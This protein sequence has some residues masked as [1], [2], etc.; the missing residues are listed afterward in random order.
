VDVVQSRSGKSF[1]AVGLAM[2][3]FL[4]GVLSFFFVGGGHAASAS[5]GVIFSTKGCAAT[6]EIGASTATAKLSG[7]CPGSY[8]IVSNKIPRN[9]VGIE[10]PSGQVRIGVA[11][12][13]GGVV[14]LPSCGAFQ[15]D[16]SK[17]NTPPDTPAHPYAHVISA[18][19]ALLAPCGPSTGEIAAEIFR[20]VN[21]T[22][23]TTPAPNAGASLSVPDPLMKSGTAF[24]LGAVLQ[25][26][27]EALGTWTMSAVAPT[28]WVFS[29]CG[30]SGSTVQSL[31]DQSLVAPASVSSQP[32]PTAA[33]ETQTNAGG[34]NH[35]T[36]QVTVTATGHSLVAFYANALATAPTTTTSTSTTSTSTTS[37]TVP[38]KSGSS[39]T[40]GTE[41]V[42]CASLATAT[43]S[44]TDKPSTVPAFT[45]NP[46]LPTTGVPLFPELAMAGGLLGLGVIAVRS[47]RLRKKDAD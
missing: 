20:C 15:V 31:S 46:S 37:T 8:V 44:T 1:S 13:P 19:Q 9:Q 14:D 27:K 17:L 43:T 47:T 12:L 11:P 36:A 40:G 38:C 29:S 33:S 28:G 32:G 22:P 45:S 21:G 18:K 42:S 2:G 25:A 6:L 35:A 10:P 16:V 34:S 4:S 24:A 26:T 30:Q 7:T 5:G 23:T 41:T 39:A 3:L